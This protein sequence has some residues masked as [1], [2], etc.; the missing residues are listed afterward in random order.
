MLN[1]AVTEF[2]EVQMQDGAYSHA[3]LYLFIHT[4]GDD[5]VTVVALYDTAGLR[6]PA[7]D[8]GNRT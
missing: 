7:F 8:Q 3:L 4:A 1:F 2:C 5:L 6:R